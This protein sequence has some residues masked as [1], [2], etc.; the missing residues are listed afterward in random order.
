M[1]R[2]SKHFFALMMIMVRKLLLIGMGFLA[3]CSFGL[4]HAMPEAQVVALD[5][6]PAPA[7]AAPLWVLREDARVDAQTTLEQI[8]QLP[9]TAFE[10]FS[11]KTSYR[12]K[13]NEPLWLRLSV[14]K[15]E[16]MRHV[17]WLLEFPTAV[18]DRYELYQQDTQGAWTMM[19]AGDE[20]AY[21]KWPIRSMRPR[22][23]LYGNPDA[24]SE[25][26]VRVLHPMP[27]TMAP[28]LVHQQFASERDELIKIWM[29]LMVGVIF[30]LVLL[31]AQ[32]MVA[33]RDPLYAWYGSYL[34]FALLTMVSYHGL[35]QQLLWPSAEKFSNDSISLFVMLAAA[36][37]LQ[38]ARVMFGSLQRRW[39]H[40]FVNVLIIS[41]IAY[42]VT[43]LF[44]EA[45]YRINPIY[46]P[47]CIV[48]FMM[49]I[50]S[51]FSAWRRGLA[52]G[53]YWILIY[54]PFLLVAV[55]V[56]LGSV[57]WINDAWIPSYTTL[58]VVTLEAIGM[59]FFINAFGRRR[60]AQAVREQEALV[61]DPL[62][63][64]LKEDNFTERALRA[65]RH[66]RHSQREVTLVYLNVEAKDS[67]IT[68]MQAEALM[69]R[70]VRM[71]RTTVREFDTVGRLGPKLFGILMLNMPQNELLSQRLSRLVALGLMNDPQDQT[72]VAVNFKI[73]AASYQRFPEEFRSVDMALRE[74]LSRD[75]QG[76][77][78]PIRFLGETE[79]AAPK[80]EGVADTVRL[81]DS[82]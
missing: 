26:F 14:S 19:V 68:D 63:G 13:P 49:I 3:W 75:E 62:T 25:V 12:I 70:S 2:P 51:G 7:F 28:I 10:P 37:N 54:L 43:R 44:V 41:C 81:P 80:A 8:R 18:V 32:T 6:A 77:S 47:L 11:A 34:F 46:G 22:F 60:H 61:R 45:Y 50:Y 42:A 24:N 55:S 65:W 21:E 20:V 9:A 71:I 39:Y 67:D 40:W 52:L 15:G 23:P 56:I 36:C 72:S 27:A 38:F 82:A 66:A 48:S 33:F 76:K 69:L 78:K 17:N 73:A 5:A 29:G 30:T 53:G 57:G 31:C 79:H 35:G 16:P 4:A 64:F 59:M 1:H 58:L 74:L